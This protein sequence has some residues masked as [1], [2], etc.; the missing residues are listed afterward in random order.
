MALDVPPPC[1]V[2]D[3]TK[4]RE[5]HRRNLLEKLPMIVFLRPYRCKECGDRFWR[6]ALTQATSAER[7]K[8]DHPWA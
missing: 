7:S 8:N 2:C 3:S 1:P 4:I 5:S 6:F